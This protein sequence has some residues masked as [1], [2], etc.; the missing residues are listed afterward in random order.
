MNKQ[1]CWGFS[2]TTI[3]L[4]HVDLLILEKTEEPNVLK[5]YIDETMRT[6]S[7]FNSSSEIFYI[8]SFLFLFLL[9]EK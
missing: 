7:G 3:E 1:F 5:L 4:D 6:K 8:L 2:L 9:G